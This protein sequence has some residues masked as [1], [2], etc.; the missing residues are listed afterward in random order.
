MTMRQYIQKIATGPELSKDLSREEARD[1]MGCI[2]SGD[3]DPVQAAIFLIALRMKR[4]TMPEN[5]GVLDALLEYTCQARTTVDDVLDL[6]DPFDGFTRGMPATP[7]LPA[8]LAA[9]GMATVSNGAESIGPKY[10]ATHRKV[11]RAAGANVDLS[12]EEASRQL[13]NKDVGW[14]YVDQRTACPELHDLVSLRTKIVK[15][16]CLTTLE[17]LLGPVRGAKRTH[18]V[19]GYVHKPYPP[20]YTALARLSGYAS[21]I[22][23]RGVEGGVI[24]SLNQ[25]SKL[26]FY[27]EEESDTEIRLDPADYAI[28]SS[29]RAVPLPEN[30]PRR[31]ADDEIKGFIDADALAQAAA[32]AGL[33]ALAGEAGPVRESLVYGAALCLSQM[34]RCPNPAAAAEKVR[35][36]LDKGY[37]AQRFEAAVQ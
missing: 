35:L 18:L 6:S 32:T 3:A 29:G 21:A 14:A 19:T 8:V 16:P 36:V 11:L 37:A 23:V 17:V 2:L 13:A 24:P 30:L 20:I 34:G 22:I 25:P 15:R 4:E 26:F 5:Q 28:E 31:E 27:Q 7:F 33:A 12:P 9:C 1:G 10:G